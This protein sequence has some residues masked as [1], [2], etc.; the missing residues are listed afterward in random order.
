MAELY[1]T[2][3]LPR[4]KRPTPKTGQNDSYHPYTEDTGYPHDGRADNAAY[5]HYGRADKATY[6]HDGCADNAAYP[7]TV[8][9]ITPLIRT[10]G[11]SKALF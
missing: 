10:T 2:T 11:I 1:E 8:V 7:P 6:P 3:Y 4:P 9:L 5:P